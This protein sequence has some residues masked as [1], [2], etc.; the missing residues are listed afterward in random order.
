[1]SE[2]PKNSEHENQRQRWLKYGLNVLLTS[3]IVIVLAGLIVYIAQKEDARI[4]VTREHVYSLKPQT[5][6]IIRDLKQPITLVSLYSRSDHDPIE[7]SRA[8][9]VADLLHEYQRRGK[10]INVELI[11]PV[12]EPG[13]VDH[14]IDQVTNKYGGEIAAYRKVVTDYS[15]DYDQINKLATE[16]AQKVASLPLEQMQ[17]QGSAA[18]QSVVLAL[19]T[20]QQMPGQLKDVKTSVEK[21]TRQKLPDW[22]GAVDAIDDGMNT[23]SSLTGQIIDNFKKLSTDPKLPEVVRKYMSTSLPDYEKIKTIADDMHTR[24]S[25]LGE[26]K[27][28]ELRTQLRQRDSILVMGNSDMRTISE[29][30]VWQEQKDVQ[31][32]A[33]NARPIKPEFAG[34]QQI[35]TAILALNRTTKPIVVFVRPGGAPLTTPGNAFQQGGLLSRVAEML[36]NYGFRVVEKDLSGQYAMQ[37]QMQGMPAPEEATPEQLKKG[38]WVALGYQ[39]QRSQMGQPQASIAPAVAEHLKQGGSALILP[40]PQ[41]ED[42]ANALSP[43]GIV[44]H[45]NAWAVHEK[46]QLSDNASEIEQAKAAPFVWVLNS[47]GDSPIGKPL[48]SLD[49]VFVPVLPIS[50]AK[51]ISP[52]TQPTTEPALKVTNSTLLPLPNTVPSWGETDLTDLQQSLTAKYEPDKGDL[53]PPLFGGAIAQRGKS[54]VVVIGASRFAFDQFVSYPDL[55]TLRQTGRIVAR[56]PANAQLFMDSIF[57]LAHENTMLAI[58]PTAMDA[59][60]IQAIPAGM[61]N[62]WRGGILLVILP[63]L[64]II[65]GIG[66]YF[67][68]RD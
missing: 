16:Q 40:F 54:R 59:P 63:G 29:D 3:V 52:S 19:V 48:K 37:A 7:T 45:T 25:K 35:S 1:M 30:K 58:A 43:Y 31:Q 9:T 28:D 64:V 18:L 53:P 41:S 38:I 46:L 57:W 20:V 56:F 61:L 62:F 49:G 11:D 67:A 23:M 24:I 66:V 50:V 10:N 13:K 51:P 55:E 47:Y 36:R 34:E 8:Q 12:S 4:D 6:N 65:A 22:R 60:R 44:V 15:S 39:I 5:L 26:L 42:F 68:R 17:G 2:D 32:M 14:L 33:A 27:L 21:I